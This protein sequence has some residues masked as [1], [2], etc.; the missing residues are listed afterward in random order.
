KVSNMR[1][2]KVQG[3]STS[4]KVWRA[5]MAPYLDGRPVA[6]AEYTAA[7]KNQPK[8]DKTWTVEL[9]P[10]RHELTVLAGGPETAG[11]S[12]PVVVTTPLPLDKRPVLH[13]VAVGIDT[14]SNGVPPLVGAAGDAAAI[15]AALQ[16]H[17]AGPQNLFGEVLVH[18]PVVGP[19]G[20][21]A[22][23]D[24]DATRPAVLAALRNARAAAKPGDLVVF[25]FAGHGVTQGDNFYLLTAEADP[26]KL[27]ATAISAAD[28]REQL[29]G[30][31]C[32]TL[33]VFDA[34]QSAAG[35]KNLQPATEQLATAGTAD[36]VRVTV[37]TAAGWDEK[38]VANPGGGLLT[39]ALTKALKGEGVG[40]NPDDRT[41]YVLHLYAAV[42][43]DVQRE[44]K[45]RQHPHLQMPWNAPA[46]AIRKAP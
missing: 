3:G 41:I 4:A 40:Y 31:R 14:Y 34:C 45:G 5:F 29:S 26:D 35:V 25:F 9:P 19:K 28:F 33:A 46:L 17:C 27:A 2:G 16:K 1:G 36:D 6:G 38:A 32:P 15:V 43:N 37:L 23:A 30:M 7:F 24:K 12:D 8:A 42:F 18:N 20:G 22:L 10:G 13:V 39:Q 44:S 11:W 21:S